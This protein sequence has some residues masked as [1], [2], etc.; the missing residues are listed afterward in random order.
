MVATHSASSVIGKFQVFVD[1]SAPGS[2]DLIQQLDAASDNIS[3]VGGNIYEVE[4]SEK[5]ILPIISSHEDAVLK[6]EAM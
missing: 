4:T 2:L 5:A 6:F 1:G 3:H